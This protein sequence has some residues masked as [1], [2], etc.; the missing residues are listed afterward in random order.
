MPHNK[1]A[2]EKQ[3]SSR[4]STGISSEDNKLGEKIHTGHSGPEPVT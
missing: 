1:L 2:A 4:I 3:N